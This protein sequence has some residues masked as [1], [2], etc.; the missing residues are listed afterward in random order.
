MDISLQQRQHENKKKEQIQGQV[1]CMG[2]TSVDWDSNE[3]KVRLTPFT[4]ACNI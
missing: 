2:S 4:V 1:D 3:N